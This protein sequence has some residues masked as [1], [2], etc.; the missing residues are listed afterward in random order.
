MHAAAK[1]V[2]F[3]PGLRVF[4]FD[5]GALGTDVGDTVLGAAAGTGAREGVEWSTVNYTVIANVETTRVDQWFDLDLV[6][7][8]NRTVAVWGTDLALPTR[9]PSTDI[10]YAATRLLGDPWY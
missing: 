7:P 10:V 9:M 8:P 5:L 1:P 4:V 6:I 2:K 3:V